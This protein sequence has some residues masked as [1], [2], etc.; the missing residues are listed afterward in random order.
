V[1]L[2]KTSKADEYINYAKHCLKIAE[3]LPEQASRILLREMG[4][5]WIKLAHAM[6][7]APTGKKHG[8]N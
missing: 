1:K 8:Q 6:T 7:D 3:K 2:S 4:A 5:E